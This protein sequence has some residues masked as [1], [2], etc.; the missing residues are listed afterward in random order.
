MSVPGRAEEIRS[1]ALVLDGNI[2]RFSWEPSTT[3]L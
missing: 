3:M 2:P 1:L